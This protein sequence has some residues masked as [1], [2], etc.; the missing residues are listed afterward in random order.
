MKLN[1]EMDPWKKICDDLGIS[2]GMDWF[3]SPTISSKTIGKHGRPE[4]LIP[5]YT[6]QQLRKHS[7]LSSHKL[8]PIRIGR[9]E[10]VL[11]KASLIQDAPKSSQSDSF[12]IKLSSKEADAVQKFTKLTSD[13]E[14]KL[15]SIAYNHGVFSRV[16]NKSD[17]WDYSLGIFG[18][19][20]LPKTEIGLVDFEGNK[21][22]YGLSISNVQFELDFSFEDESNIFIIEAKVGVTKTFSSLQLFYPYLFFK[23]YAFESEKKIRPILLL[24]QNFSKEKIHYKILEYGFRRSNVPN[25][26]YLKEETNVSLIFSS[27]YY[28]S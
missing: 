16:F 5:I 9:G 1:I 20:N 3:V 18:K 2:D 8:I 27:Q 4:K 24:M 13:N 19:M 25:S 15:L 17:N 10:A 11:T 28:F 22:F 14:A 6:R 21:Q 7:F 26:L 12:S 23:K